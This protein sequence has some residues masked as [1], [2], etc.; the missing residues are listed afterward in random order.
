[1]EIIIWLLFGV[2]CYLIAEKKNRNPWLAALLGCLFGVFALIGYAVVGKKEL[3]S[4]T[5]PTA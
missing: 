2:A 4:G 5:N 1:M 3:P